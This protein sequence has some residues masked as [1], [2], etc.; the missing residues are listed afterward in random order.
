[1][2]HGLRRWV[3]TLLTVLLGVVLLFTFAITRRSARSIYDQVLDTYESSLRL[4]AMNLSGTL[5]SVELSL[6]SLVSAQTETLYAAETGGGGM[7]ALLASQS[8]NSLL[9]Q[10]AQFSSTMDGAFLL[11]PDGS[12]ILAQYNAYSVAEL[13]ALKEALAGEET[14]QRWRIARVGPR[15]CL[16]RTLGFDLCRLG[17]YVDCERLLR[18]LRN[19][20]LEAAADY[21]LTD[22]GGAVYADRLAGE[23][24]EGLRLGEGPLALSGERMLPIGAPLNAGGLRLA[25][26]LRLSELNR[27]LYRNYWM[28]AAFAA[29]VSLF[30]LLIYRAVCAQLLSPVGRLTETL[31]AFSEGD[32][33]ARVTEKSRIGEINQL[34]EAYNGMAREVGE[35][36]IANYESRLEKNRTELQ[37]LQLQIQ[38]HFL[39]NTLNTIYT[40][41]QGRSF[42]LIQRLTMFLVKYYRYTIK[43]TGNFV[44]LRDELEHV[45]NYLGIHELRLGDRLDVFYDVDEALLDVA[46]PP[47]V[48]QTFVE[49][50]VQ[51]AV[52]MDDTTFLGIEVQRDREDGGRM[53]ITISDTGAGFPEDCLTGE[54]VRKDGK[55]HIGIA[56]VR[57]RLEIA[58]GGEAAMTLSNTHPHGA[59]VDIVIPIIP[60]EGGDMT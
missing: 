1:M 49:N 4:Y 37:F 47:I 13:D 9:H 44:R 11:R 15:W 6:S 17:V 48:L 46:I 51:Y 43:A 56:N 32:M 29:A 25:A 3:R 22:D 58:Y 52:S 8:L 40:L 39:I 30:M 16:L 24:A 26:V 42:D 50:S 7:A 31:R 60:Y 14:S 45:K 28:G 57:Q 38:P 35:L 20:G 10:N 21:C 53:H 34:N 36:K 59:K 19:S 41:A 5:R 23:P 12:M 18:S 2:P 27:G 33:D 54:P 55:L